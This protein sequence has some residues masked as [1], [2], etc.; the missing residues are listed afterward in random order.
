M[1]AEEPINLL[2][3]PWDRALARVGEFMRTHPVTMTID[4]FHALPPLFG[5]KTE[6]FEGALHVEPRCYSIPV[7]ARLRRR[8]M[9]S[10]LLLRPVE[11]FD[12]K[13]LTDLFYTSFRGTI[14]Y[15]DNPAD[16]IRQSARECVNG[17]YSRAQ[18]LPLEAGRVALDDSGRIA[19]AAL[20]V[21]STRGPSLNL[22]MVRPDWQ[23]QGV[24]T[25]MVQASMSV[26]Y[27]AGECALHSSYHVLNLP[28]LRWHTSMGFTVAHRLPTRGPD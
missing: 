18:D 24:A 11:P 25:A 21:Q 6:Y 20:I 28:S 13:E 7:R 2:G 12:K 10:R 27:A 23:H 19:G 4:E 16:R 14:D 5:L 9:S 1:E 3:P 8:P 15:C 22:L 17:F 26:L